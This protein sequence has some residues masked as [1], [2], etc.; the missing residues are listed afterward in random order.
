MN[1]LNTIL[2]I[3]F[4]VYC[5]SCG[6]SGMDLCLECLSNCSS[7]EYIDYKWI[8]PI[9]DYHD[10]LVK[11]SIWFLKYKGKKRL[12]TIFATIMYDR[13]IEE[14]SDLMTFENFK[15]P[16]LIPIPLA[17]KRK[18]ER[19][20]NQAEVICNELIKL[21]KNLKL[22]TNVLIKQKDT[23]HQAS[24]KNRNERLKNLT[25]SFSIKNPEKIKNKNIILIDDVSTTGATLNEAKKILKQAGAKKIIAFAVAH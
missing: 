12:G 19:G 18:R 10:P 13:I 24:I 16:I 3:I 9:F 1:F 11:K 20:F 6:K 4:P 7:A 8:Y 25:D 23:K 17:P 15:D 2:D 22:E 14:L 21:D 5:I